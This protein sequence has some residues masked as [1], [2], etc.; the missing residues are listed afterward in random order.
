MYTRSADRISAQAPQAS[1]R[2][3]RLC[4]EVLGRFP[5]FLECAHLDLPDA[6]TR[7]VEVC[8]KIFERQWLVDQISRLEDATLATVQYIDRDDQGLMLV[9]L[10]VVFDDDGFRRG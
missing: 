6:F 2:C 7:H 9:L 3:R 1:H 10:L 8:R 4:S 5:H